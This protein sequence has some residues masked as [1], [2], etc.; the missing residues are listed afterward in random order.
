[1]SSPLL[2]NK[3]DTENALSSIFLFHA[4]S[5]THRPTFKM[6]A[7]RPTALPVNQNY[8]RPSVSRFGCCPTFI[9]ISVSI[10]IGTTT[11]E[12]ILRRAVYN[13]IQ[14]KKTPGKYHN[15]HRQ[16]MNGYNCWETKRKFLILITNIVGGGITNV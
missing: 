16:K 7:E 12:R 9:S 11:V 2:T 10:S 6:V 5:S 15:G 14:N 4:D 1:M 3:H 13:P 8:R